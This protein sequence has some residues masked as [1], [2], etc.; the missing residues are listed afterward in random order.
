MDLHNN[1]VGISYAFRNIKQ[2]RRTGIFRRDVI[3]APSN[4]TIKIDIKAK[5]DIAIKVSEDVA[6]MKSVNANALVYYQ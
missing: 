1:A 6:S 3:I 4:E 5:A 2:E